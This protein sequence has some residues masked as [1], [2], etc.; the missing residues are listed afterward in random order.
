MHRPVADDTP[1]TWGLNTT[2]VTR[3]RFSGRGVRVAILDTGLDAGH[4]DFAGRAVRSRSFLPNPSTNDTNGHGTYCAGIA[5]GPSRPDRPPRYGIAS[6]AE[7]W[8]AKVIDDVGEGKD[9]NILAALDWSIDC[10]CAIIGLSFGTP[11]PR[12]EPHSPAYERIAQRA[13]AEGSLIVAAAGNGSLRPD[14]IAPV[15]HPA[16]CPSILTVA[17]IDQN[18][19]LAPFSGAGIN[20]G[21]EIDLVAPGVAVCSAWPG[22]DLHRTRSG[23]SMAT[24]YV[25]GIA[26]LWAEAY[27]TIRGQALKDLIRKHAKPLPHAPR[28]VGAG[29]VQA[30]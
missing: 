21:G 13:L 4:P 19:R 28:D 27:P 23:T 20:P 14:L 26:A 5:C 30:P 1:S 17:A 6:D 29:L 24:S 15:D 3:S 2:G 8:V 25:V 18:L 9:S 16:N 12:G 7:L 11:V 10:G 22:P